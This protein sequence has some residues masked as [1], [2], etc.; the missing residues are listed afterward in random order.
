VPLGNLKL[1]CIGTLLEANF[2]S[3]AT[4]VGFRCSYMGHLLE[5]V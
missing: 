3:P 2:R 4:H 5:T 1:V